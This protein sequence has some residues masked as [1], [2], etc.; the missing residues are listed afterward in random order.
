MISKHNR[1]SRDNFEK[2]MKK[3]GFLNSSFFTLRFLKDPLNSIHFSVVVAKKVAKT[4]VS[5]N[6][7]RRRAYSVLGRSVKNPR[8]RGQAYFVILFGKKGV[9]KATFAEVEADILLAL[10]KAKN[11]L[12]ST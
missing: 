6:K 11:P 5:R 3:G 4:A 8:L 10:E 7:I 12:K 9:E 1:I 2:V